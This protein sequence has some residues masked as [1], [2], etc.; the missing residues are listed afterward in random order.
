MSWLLPPML[1][2]DNP[3]PRFSVRCLLAA[4]SFM[5]GLGVATP[6][7]S[8]TAEGYDFGENGVPVSARVT[9]ER[10]I[11]D[12]DS[13]VIVTM[14]RT[15]T[16]T[17]NVDYT[18][19]PIPVTFSN[20]ESV[21]TIEIRIT[22]DNIVELDETFVLALT[23]VENATIGAADTTTVT[24]LND[25]SATISINDVTT[26][27]GNGTGFRWVNFTVSMSQPVD[28]QIDLVPNLS[29]G[30]TDEVLIA[31]WRRPILPPGS[32]S[33]TISVSVERDDIVEL[34]EQFH[35]NLV[36]LN[37]YGR[38]VTLAKS[39]GI[40][41][42]LN[43]D[44]AVITL[45]GSDVVEGDD[46]RSKMIFT[47]TMNKEVDVPV[48][49]LV[50]ASEG[51]ATDGLDFRRK[52]ET[53]TLTTAGTPFEIEIIP[54]NLAEDDETI[55]VAMQ[56]RFLEASGR[57]VIFKNDVNGFLFTRSILDDDYAPIANA[58]GPY[59]VVE[60][61]ILTVGGESGLLANDTDEDD[62]QALLTA[63]LKSGPTHGSLALNPDG[64]F[65]YTPQRDF[66]GKDSFTYSASDGTN[67]SP[68]QTVNINII[69]RTDLAVGIDLLQNPLVAGGEARDVFRVTV[70]N[71]GPSDATGVTVIR[72]RMFH[73][74]VF[75]VAANPSSGTFSEDVWTL[76]L[77]ENASATLL[78]SVQAGVEV[79]GRSKV[80]RTAFVVGGADQIETNRTNNIAISS[81][82]IISAADTG[83]AISAVPQVDLQSGLFVSKVTVTN[84]NHATIPA[85][86]LLV[87]NLPDD[88]RVHNAHD[89]H[90]DGSSYLL[91][92]RPLA[93]GASITLSVEF[94]RP[95][96]NPDFTPQ[97]AVELLPVAETESEP[98]A[99]GIPVTRN[100]RLS[101]GDHLIEIAS[102][103][104]AL[105]A[106]EYSG[107]MAL[108]TRVTPSVTAAANRLQW[109]DNGPPKTA[110][111]PS[112]VPSRYYRFVLISSPSPTPQ[113]P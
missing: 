81:A 92:I 98:A 76:D 57:D 93:P 90:S 88:V 75:L 55:L 47:A 91:H 21:K 17:A 33:H 13:S 27:E 107:D 113:E 29:R 94:F 59:E 20:G 79:S 65:S 12:G 1:P 78:L 26:L 66:H 58:D 71:H 99:T 3:M 45:T 73:T 63:R 16:A 46:G 38:D 40:G 102:A 4:F 19:L 22:Q 5:G 97:Y 49:A 50:T 30:L 37:T 41:T 101:N 86:R 9:L 18:D 28:T 84:T 2:S 44:Q 95:S 108:W 24:I 51:S 25:D 96:L 60:D 106:V 7:V 31:F 8:F 62:G 72:R 68:E 103:P 74:N 39:Q 80:V 105:Y 109:I 52:S 11:A 69:E 83:I 110:N 10:D 70:T 23:A 14:P 56:N 53:I 6:V 35:V 87:K 15:G 77:A 67:E 100:Q 89:T 85:L 104:G 64:G 43:D 111:H 82:D 36:G 54:D 61:G 48:T 32:L 112:S 34:D 42:I